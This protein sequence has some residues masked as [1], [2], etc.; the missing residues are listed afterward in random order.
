MNKS[1]LKKALNSGKK[2][3]FDQ[4]VLEYLGEHAKDWYNF[5]RKNKTQRIVDSDT[6]K[7]V[8]EFEANGTKYYIRSAKEGI[9]IERYTKLRQMLSI[10]GF[11]ATFADQV[12]AINR[13]KKYAN[14]LVT[15]DPQLDKLFAEIAN[16]EEAITRTDRKFDFSMYAATLFIFTEDE[17]LTKW[18][19][20]LAEK[21]IKD[22]NDAKIHEHDFFLLVSLWP[23]Q[24][25]EL[26]EKSQRHLI[27][28]KTKLES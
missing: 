12:A 5:R 6:G 20:R 8:S 4:V 11:D 17:D 22:W 3:E 24:L 7:W 13:I 14:S 15:K 18:D 28:A 10:V 25:I 26:W 9:G 1:E 27:L 2:G 16:M 23:V 21:K 19:E